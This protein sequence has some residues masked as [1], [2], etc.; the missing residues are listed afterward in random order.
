M[1]T[2]T[3]G[4]A[5]TPTVVST[6]LSHYLKR[7][8]LAHKPTERLSYDQGLHL[9][10]SFLAHASRHTVE[11]LQ[12]FTSQWVPHPQWV[13]VDHVEIPEKD[14]LRAADLLA[15]QLGPDGIR[16]VGGREWWQWR[17]PKSPLKAEWIEM[18]ADYQARK[19][20]ADPGNRVMLYVHGGAYFFGSVDEHRYQIQRHARKLKARALAPRYRL[21]P[22]FPFPCGLQ[23][24][25][26]TYLYLITQQSPSTIILAGDSAG[27]GMILSLMVI[28]RDRG[29]PLPAGAVLI[30]P[31]V[32]LTHSFPSVAGDC[33]LD[34]IPSSGFHHKPSPAWPPPDEEEL[35]A[36]KKAAVAQKKNIDGKDGEPAQDS[37][38]P[39]VK[40]VAE[41]THRL[42]FLID[43]EQVEIKE[44]I[45]MYTTNELLAHPLVSPV[46]QPTLGGL[47]PLLI[48]VGGGELLRDEQIYLAHKCANPA[49]H[50]PPE[51]LMDEKARA[52]VD[53]YKPTDVQLQVWDDMCHVGPTL[54]FTR[55]A[56][57]MYRSV[58]QFSAWALARAQKTEVDILNDDEISVISSSS[59]FSSN[60][61][62]V[63]KPTATTSPPKT[64]TPHHPSIGKAGDPLPP[65]QDHMIRQRVTRHGAILPL[66][67]PSSLPGCCMPR[68]LVG[69][70]KVGTV[71]KWLEHKRRWDVRF[72]Q[73]KARVHDKRLRDMAAGGYEVFGGEGEVPPPSALAG[74]RRLGVGV[75]EGEK[76]KRKKKKVKGLGLSLW[77]LWGSKHDEVVVQREMQAVKAPE[78]G[79][80]DGAG[81]GQGARRFSDLGRQEREARLGEEG[82]PSAAETSKNRAW[83]GLVGEEQ[84][85][86]GG[87]A[88]PGE[89]GLDLRPAG[90]VGDSKEGEEAAPSRTSRFLSPNDAH[91]T[92]ITGK[93]VIIGGL[94]TPFSLRKEPD[95]A[96]MITLASPM[97]QGSTRPSTAGSSSFVAD[98]SVKVHEDQDQAKGNSDK[99]DED[100]GD[101]QDGLTPG[102]ATPFLTPFLSPTSPGE[103][104][105]LERFVTAEEVTKASA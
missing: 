37:G 36:L 73:T 23:D 64:T 74:R 3:V 48:M 93:R 49:Q 53:R 66:P 31:W 85:E 101:D 5:V 77:A 10:R 102:L 44:Q 6:F 16:Q 100:R 69:V 7:K 19:K 43:G 1:N 33:P 55:P 47:P 28:L 18:K 59:S 94:A 29:I 9:I 86:S 89:G 95:T 12:A 82:V 81:Q 35:E 4:L 14:L 32:D 99:R 34:Y 21:A 8:P 62:Q 97:D 83:R 72:R 61:S 25:L 68:D 45:Q 2:A 41:A 50:L 22:Q 92:G 26:A 42:T 56:K 13:R 90:P 63:P 39:T 30:S 80:A 15:E 70:V 58:A 27:G 11:E 103:R 91:D 46:M 65:F 71:R 84:A 40:D 96:S 51:A 54:S 105:D 79:G 52:L 75:G 38:I 78:L 17:K 60:E 20:K 57:Y 88:A 98:P 87:A 104:P 76:K 24:C 67:D